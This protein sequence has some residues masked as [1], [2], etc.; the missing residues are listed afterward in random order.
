MSYSKKQQDLE[1]GSYSTDLAAGTAGQNPFIITPQDGFAPPSFADALST[2]SPEDAQASDSSPPDYFE[3]S[4]LPQQNVLLRQNVQPLEASQA[5]YQRKAEGISSFDERLQANP[6]ELYRFFLTHLVEK[7]GLLVN[8][9]GTHTETRHHNGKSE[10]KTVVDFN[11]YRTVTWANVG[12]HTP[13]LAAESGQFRKALEEFT[14]SKNLLKEN[15]WDYNNLRKAFKTA[16][17]ATGYRYNIK[18]TFTRPNSSITIFSSST[19]SQ[20][21]QSWITWVLFGTHIK[22]VSGRLAAH[23]P[24]AVPAATFFQRNVA[25]GDGSGKRRAMGKVV[26]AN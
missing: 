3:I 11:F 21:A 8:C 6:D 13:N 15:P 17:R 1:M 12:A 4:L 9:K 25:T 24:I 20:M 14:T 26:R 23:F 16:I 18:I 7:P 2:L 22:K 19:L 10:T 5:V